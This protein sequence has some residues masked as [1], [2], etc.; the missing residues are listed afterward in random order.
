MAQQQE[1]DPVRVFRASVSAVLLADGLTS[2]KE[3]A[4]RTL[5]A[6]CYVVKR[7]IYKI[8]FFA[9]LAN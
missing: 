3:T 4:K 9:I 8:R 5:I 1:L 7:V 6:T 2:P